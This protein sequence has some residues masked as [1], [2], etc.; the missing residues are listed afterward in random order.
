MRAFH[1]LMMMLGALAV[2]T[3]GA[4]PA[5]AAVDGSPALSCHE[6]M[7]HSADGNAPSPASDTATKAMDCCLA[8]VAAPN[9]RAPDRARLAAPRPPTVGHPTMLPAGERPAPEP[10]PP[11]PTPF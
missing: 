2:L 4:L 1:A 3:V 6:S 11:R 5:R 7:P 8:C 9:L 10:H